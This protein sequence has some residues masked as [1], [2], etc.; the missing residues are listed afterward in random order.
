MGTG[1]LYLWGCVGGAIACVI[2][3]ILPEVVHIALTGEVEKA[4]TPLRVGAIVLM[5]VIFSLIGGV[6]PLVDG[7]VN[8]P[9]GAIALGVGAQAAL[10]GLL[11]AGQEALRSP[12]SE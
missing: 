11:N 12:K 3:Y 2:V 5:L 6:A 10:K 1:E 7:K 8:T 9:G 4:I